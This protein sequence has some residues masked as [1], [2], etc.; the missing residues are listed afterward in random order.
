MRH[1]VDGER[2]D[3]VPISKDYM[4]RLKSRVGKPS[5]RAVRFDSNH[6][7]IAPMHYLTCSATYFDMYAQDEEFFERVTK[8]DGRSC[9]RDLSLPLP[10]S[11]NGNANANGDGSHDKSGEF[12][13][14]HIFPVEYLNEVRPLVLIEY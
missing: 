7:L 4:P 5:T 9:V 2:V 1:N 12:A 14:A 3:V 6:L 11:T 10:S 8:R 13:A